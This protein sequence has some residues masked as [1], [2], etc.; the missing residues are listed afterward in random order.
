[1]DRI[2]KAAN[3]IPDKPAIIA[4]DM[5]DNEEVCTWRELDVA[6]ARW[7]C[8][9]GELK[10]CVAKPVIYLK[11]END[12]ATVVMLLGC[13]RASVPFVPLPR[14]MPDLAIQEIV[15]SIRKSYGEPVRASEAYTPDLPMPSRKKE[16][17]ED[18]RAAAS[19]SHY[20]LTSGSTGKRK[21]MPLRAPFLDPR[22]AIP[23]PVFQH[24]GWETGQRQMI[25]FP[26]SHIASFTALFEG[27][28]DG[29]C[30]LLR[31]RFSAQSALAAIE[32][33]NVQWILTCPPHMRRLVALPGLSGKSLRPIRAL[34]HTGLPCPVP[35]KKE[36]LRLLPH[37]RL[38]EMY[39]ATESIGMTLARGTD[40]VD[41]PGTV[42][43]GFLTRLRIRTDDGKL[44][45]PGE[46]GRVYM[47]RLGAS[48][49]LDRGAWLDW[50]PDGYCSL[51][52]YG[53][54]DNDGYLYL[55]GRVED[56]VLRN[57]KQFWPNRVEMAL[58]AH[59]AVKDVACHA[60][61]DRFYAVIVPS[62]STVIDASELREY[63]THEL[64]EEEVPAA[65]IMA[66][67]LPRD[68]VGKIQ[69]NELRVIIDKWLS[70]KPGRRPLNRRLMSWSNLCGSFQTNRLCSHLVHN[71]PTAQSLSCPVR[72]SSGSQSYRPQLSLADQR[73]APF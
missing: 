10:Q 63:C 69:R 27:M 34:V 24:T 53:W 49:Q 19:P 72:S 22:Y 40:W 44:L 48:D 1:M 13:L 70:G 55:S 68:D 52:D 16:L 20:L 58:G 31:E 11:A 6:S 42:G 73:C 45:P 15:D 25:T 67:R 36:W 29:G 37:D 47:R 61:N 12:V 54:L 66:D 3:R 43:R 4:I 59:P 46:V 41:R 32:H 7:A 64:D 71:S 21:L 33:Y 60:A 38:F 5:D 51:G 50:S 56:R 39:G 18:Q 28:L 62:E 8:A 26:I 57:G 23:N 14:D 65:F 2:R 35:L 17:P 9:L 30:T